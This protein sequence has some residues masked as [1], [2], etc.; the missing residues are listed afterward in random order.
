MAMVGKQVDRLLS[1]YAEDAISLPNFGPRMEGIDAFR[2]SH[3]AMNAAGMNVLS[4]DSEPT[5]VWQAGDQV[6]EIGKFEIRLEMPGMPNTIGEEPQW[7]RPGAQR[8]NGAISMS[9]LS[10]S[11]V[12]NW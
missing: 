1:M 8:V 9:K 10:P 5:D 2:Q 6:I 12:T 7:T 3:E 11:L 4:F